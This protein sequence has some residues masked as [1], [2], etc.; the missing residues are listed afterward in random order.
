MAPLK[1]LCTRTKGG[2]YRDGRFATLADV[3]DHY[4]LA[5]GLALGPQ[6]KADLVEFVKS[7]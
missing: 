7:P 1:G 2:F 3:V 4:D 5:F 6:E